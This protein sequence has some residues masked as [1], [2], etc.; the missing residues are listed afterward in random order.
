M[1]KMHENDYIDDDDYEGLAVTT[2]SSSMDVK[3]SAPSSSSTV[4]PPGVIAPE[5]PAFAALQPLEKAQMMAKYL[6]ARNALPTLGSAAVAASSSSSANNDPK[7]ALTRAR[8]IAMQIVN[9]GS[10]VEDA[11]G[12]VITFTDEFEINDYP[13]QVT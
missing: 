8:L 7:D 9:K 5:S 1:Q 12:N 6:A 4:L 13:P 2:S 3:P 10:A 11:S